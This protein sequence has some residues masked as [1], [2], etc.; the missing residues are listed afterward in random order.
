[1]CLLLGTTIAARNTTENSRT[2]SV[3][4]FARVYK[5]QSVSHLRTNTEETERAFC[6]ITLPLRYYI[7]ALL[8]PWVYID[9]AINTVKNIKFL[10]ILGIYINTK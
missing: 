5:K 3:Q 9:I 4:T 2:V 6:I 8:L 10:Y 1:M 7:I